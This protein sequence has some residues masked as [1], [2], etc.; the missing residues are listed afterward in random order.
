MRWIRTMCSSTCGRSNGHPLSD[1][2]IYAL[3]AR[4]RRS[5][6]IGFGPHWFCLPIGPAC[7]SGGR[8]GERK[9]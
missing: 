5:T 9:G 4:L 3:V 6:G 7:W 8:D 1:P 2:A